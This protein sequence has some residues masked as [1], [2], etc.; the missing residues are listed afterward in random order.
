MVSD[1]GNCFRGRHIGIAILIAQVILIGL[2]WSKRCISVTG[3]GDGDGVGVGAGFGTR[4]AN[5][6]I[7][8][9][10]EYKRQKAEMRKLIV[11][12]DTKADDPKLLEYLRKFVVDYPSKLMRKQSTLL[13]FKYNKQAET[14]N[15][16]Y[17]GQV[18]NNIFLLFIYFLQYTL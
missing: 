9:E 1:V 15:G 11:H 6:K 16:I 13:K 18:S 7:C 12:K 8:P 17:S 4:N 3:D 14:V 2:W 10:E 5:T